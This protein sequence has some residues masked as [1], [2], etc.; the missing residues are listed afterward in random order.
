MGPAHKILAVDLKWTWV[1][2]PRNPTQRT[3]E[4]GERGRP[5]NAAGRKGC[6]LAGWFLDSKSMSSTQFL[7]QPGI[8]KLCHMFNL[9]VVQCN[10]MY[11]NGILQWCMTMLEYMYTSIYAIYIYIYIYIYMLYIYI[12]PLG[13]LRSIFKKCLKKPPELPLLLFGH[14]IPPPVVGQGHRWGHRLFFKMPNG[15]GKNI[16]RLVLKHKKTRTTTT[17]RVSLGLTLVF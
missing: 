4:G 8:C 5:D 9:C 2:T 6:R 10:V 7:G 17:S 1:N 15:G 16:H 13:P 3:V 12:W 11:V 14:P